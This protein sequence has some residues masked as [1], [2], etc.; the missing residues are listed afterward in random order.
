[1]TRA[2]QNAFLLLCLFA[3]HSY[4][5]SQQDSVSIKLYDAGPSFPGGQDSLQKFMS[6]TVQYPA[7]ERENGISGKVHMQFVVEADGSLTEITVLHSVSGG[8]DQEAIRAIKMMP[9]WIPATLNGVPVRT[10]VNF[11]VNFALQ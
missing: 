10:R 2:V 3:F 7:I 5:F 9:H 11:P 4:S 8:L 6:S 1:M